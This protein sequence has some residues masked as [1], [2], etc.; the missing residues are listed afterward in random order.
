MKKFLLFILLIITP[1]LLIGCKEKEDEKKTSE[2]PETK[3]IVCTTKISNLDTYISYTYDTKNS[4][5]K[6]AY[7]E[8][9]MNLEGYAPEA[10]EVLKKQDMCVNYETEE[11]TNCKSTVD[12]KGLKIHVD[13]VIDTI[14]KKEH[15][16]KNP[17]IEDITSIYEKNLNATCT[18]K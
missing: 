18:V 12:E 6:S 2:N 10:I 13:F 1:F 9:S 16:G 4:T 8:Y 17:T 11:F 7:A 14:I 5:I 15:G 3:E